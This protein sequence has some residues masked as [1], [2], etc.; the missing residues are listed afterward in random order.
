MKRRRLDFDE[1][2]NIMEQDTKTSFQELSCNQM[3]TPKPLYEPL[4]P[5]VLT[6]EETSKMP[7]PGFKVSVGYTMDPLPFSEHVKTLPNGKRRSEFEKNQMIS[8][9]SICL[10]V[11]GLDKNMDY[12]FFV[13]PQV[14]KNDQNNSFQDSVG[15]IK[16]LEKVLNSAKLI[17]V[18]NSE[19]FYGVMRNYFGSMD[20]I[21]QWRRNTFD[22]FLII[23]KHTNRRVW[24]SQQHLLEKNPNPQVE[25]VPSAYKTSQ[26]YTEGVYQDLRKASYNLA[27]ISNGFYNTVVETGGLNYDLTKKRNDRVGD[28]SDILERCRIEM[29]F[30]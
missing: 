30:D 11:E 6:K 18:F 7:C 12:R 28:D 5:C 8:F 26:A 24:A 9:T 14:L 1:N 2:G 21:T 27:R 22:P 3:D 10:V 23:K 25:R 19:V 13:P 29:N 15:W 20:V 4:Y 17:S 16:E